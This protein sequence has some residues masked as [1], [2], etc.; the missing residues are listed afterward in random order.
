VESKAPLHNLLRTAFLHLGE[1]RLAHVLRAFVA[2]PDFPW[3]MAICATS[4][5]WEQRAALMTRRVRDDDWFFNHP[6]FADIEME[7]RD[8]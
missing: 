3:A 2:Q 4:D 1:E 5:V 7:L 8:R 6:D